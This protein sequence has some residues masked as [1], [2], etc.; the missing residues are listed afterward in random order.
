MLLALHTAIFV[1]DVDLF[2]PATPAAVTALAADATFHPAL[3]GLCQALGLPLFLTRG[4]IAVS[5]SESSMLKSM[6][7]AHLS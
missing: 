3:T 5:F 7:I 6:H 2:R 4:G 1:P